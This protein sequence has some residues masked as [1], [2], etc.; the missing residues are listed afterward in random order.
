MVAQSSEKYD[1]HRRVTKEEN[2]KEKTFINL[3]FS[4]TTLA[5]CLSFQN[6]NS[7]ELSPQGYAL[8]IPV[9]LFHR[10]SKL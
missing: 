4:K 1:I 7:V 6:R 3:K 2:V 8:H 9:P 10:D 5:K